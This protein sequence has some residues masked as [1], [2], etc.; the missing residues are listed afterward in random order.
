ML[1]K[2]MEGVSIPFSS[3]CMN[4]KI[5]LLFKVFIFFILMNIPF[6]LDIA[7]DFME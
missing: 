1:N 6:L 2:R 5:T 4:Q 7:G 3:I